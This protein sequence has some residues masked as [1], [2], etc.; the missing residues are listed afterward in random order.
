M[1]ADDDFTKIKNKCFHCGQYNFLKWLSERQ[2]KIYF[3]VIFH[4]SK[5]K[6]SFD[7]RLETG[8]S[9]AFF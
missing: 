8:G 9:S 6:D 1:H 4:I 5:N 2:T 7:Q 3:M